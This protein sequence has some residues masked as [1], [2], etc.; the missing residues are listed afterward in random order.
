MFER[1][2]SKFKQAH[3]LIQ[4]MQ[5]IASRFVPRVRND[6]DCVGDK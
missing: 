3:F 2:L 1:A 5:Q 4:G 6:G